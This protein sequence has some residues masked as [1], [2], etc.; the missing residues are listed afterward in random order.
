[1]L[2]PRTRTIY[3]RLGSEETQASS[4]KPGSLCSL[5]GTCVR[6]SLWSKQ[7]LGI[8]PAHHQKTEGLYYQNATFARTFRE[9]LLGAKHPSTALS[10]NNLAEL[11]R[12]Q[13][14]Y[15][16]VELLY[17]RALSNCEQLLSIDHPNLQ[18]IQHNYALLLRNLGR[19]EEA[20]D[21]R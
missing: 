9:Q 11:Y 21:P 8:G 1:M 14:K 6:S 12:E 16:Q 13:G 18:L 20:K 19:D 10:L 17:V 4:G 5:R 7:S 15:A 3:E 2:R